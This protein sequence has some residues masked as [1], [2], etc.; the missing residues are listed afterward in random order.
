MRKLIAIAAVAL[1]AASANAQV[2]FWDTNT[3]EKTITIGPRVGLNISSMTGDID[4][5]KSKVG[6]NIGAAVEF[7]FIKSFGINTGLF[8]T[9]KGYKES[10]DGDKLTANAGYLEIPVM[11]SYR[12]NF[13]EDTQLQVNFGPYFAYGINGKT[14]VKIDGDKTK[15]DTFG[16]DG[17]KRFDCGLGVGTSLAISKF[18]FGV[19]YQ[20]GLT[21]LSDDDDYS[22]KNSNVSISVG[23]NF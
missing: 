19:N 2:S 17:L 14:T 4:D 21:N 8:Y 7:N 1:C 12:L 15:Y 5:A 10:Y 11:A 9:T 3:P 18:V 20:F 22:V 23:Y 6:F 13:T 16:D